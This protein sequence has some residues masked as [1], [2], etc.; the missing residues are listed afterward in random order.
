MLKKILHS[1]LIGLVTAGVILFVL[2]K[3][4]GKSVLPEQEIASYKDAVR[5]ASPAVVNVYNQAFTSSSAQLQVNNLGSGVIMSKDG[6]ILTNKHV[7]QN[8]DQIVVALQN[9]HIFDAALIGSDSLTDLAVLKIKADNLSTIP[10]NLSR[11]VHVGD[12]GLAI[13]NP[14]NLGQSVSQGII[15]AVGRSAVGEALGRQNFI[16][17]DASINRGN[18]GGALIN[19]AGELVGISTLSIGKTSNEIAEGLNFAIPIDLAND[20]M[21]KIIRDGRVIRGY[22]GVQTDILFSNGQGSSERGILITGV[23]E[24]SPAAKA[25]LQAGDIILK[26]NKVEAHSPTEMMKLIADVRPN[27]KVEVEISRLGKTYKLPVIIEE[28]TFNQ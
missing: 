4:T 1:A 16:Q 26:I 14:Y 20:V 15:S 18:S 6:Y 8:A 5:I 19:S 28:Y 24:N 9:G 25:G 22:F 23:I 17:T 21:K 27:T 12:V 7:I 2:P 11:P 3:I 13:G 10:Q